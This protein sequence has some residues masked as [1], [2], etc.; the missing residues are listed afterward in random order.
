MIYFIQSGLK[1]SIK[2]GYT[3]NNIQE[4]MQAL[5]SA[6]PEKL[7]LLATMKG[8]KDE[9]QKLHKQFAE[10]R[11]QGEWFKSNPLLNTFIQTHTDLQIPLLFTEQEEIL[12]KD[13]VA[14]WLKITLKTMDYFVTV[15]E[16][17]F[18]RLSQRIIRFRRS[19]ILD[20]IKQ[21]REY[22]L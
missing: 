3:D 9:E 2:I 8:N 12:T 6:S 16:I 15:K 11:Q 22:H 10:Y 4:R 17:P 13:E 5:Q 19:D 18:I 1:G 14:E 7:Y 20:W 21:K